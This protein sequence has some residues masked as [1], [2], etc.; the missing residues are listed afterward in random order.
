MK[1][2][3]EPNPPIFDAI[4]DGDVN[5]VREELERWK[6]NMRVGPF[7]STALYHAMSNSLGFSLD[8]VTLLLDAGADPNK[9]LSRT[10]AMVIGFFVVFVIMVLWGRAQRE[11]RDRVRLRKRVN[12]L[13]EFEN[14]P[15]PGYS[16]PLS[17]P[18]VD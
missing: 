16:L 11:E 8:V 18:T 6:V 9:G 1:I 13:P 12:D 14:P 17:D 15:L 10:A 5:A 3:F 2:P 4:D 7:Q